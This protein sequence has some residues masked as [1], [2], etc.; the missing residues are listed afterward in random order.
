[1]RFGRSFS[2]VAAG[3]VLSAFFAGAD[4][5]PVVADS[6]TNSVAPSQKGGT[7][8]LVFIRGGAA[9]AIFNGFAR[10][11]LSALPTLP[12][13]SNVEKATLRLWVNML[14]LEGSVEM[15]L[16]SIATS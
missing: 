3:V 13:G 6:Q 9:G 5:L 4:T 14:T 15:A 7:A 11:D 1:M 10:F 12:P 16:S 8:P 2:L